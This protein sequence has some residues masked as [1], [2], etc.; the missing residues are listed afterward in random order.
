MIS[1]EYCKSVITSDND[2]LIREDGSY[3]EDCYDAWLEEVQAYWSAQYRAES[4]VAVDY[5]EA[6][7]AGYY[8]HPE[9]VER[10]IDFADAAR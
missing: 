4:S 3:H 1:C 9:R 2:E 5:A 6:Y 7:D 8:K 10:A